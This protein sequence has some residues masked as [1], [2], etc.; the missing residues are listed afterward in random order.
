M[1]CGSPFGAF[2]NG[3][4]VSIFPVFRSKRWMPAKPLFCVHTLPSTCEDCAL[5]MFTCAASMFCSGGSFHCVNFCVLRSNFRI[6]AWYMLPSQRLPSLSLRRPRSP[7]GKPGFASGMGNSVT[8]PLRGSR[9]HGLERV[10]AGT[11]A[12]LPFLLILAG[13]ARHPFA[14][15]ELC[16]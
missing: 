14:V 8:L 15:R 10:T 16:R 12:E 13:H 4:Q 11:V 3:S 6:V 9:R 7:V 5:T 1:L 2:L